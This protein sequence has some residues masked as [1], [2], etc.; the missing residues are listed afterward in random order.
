MTPAGGLTTDYFIDDTGAAHNS[1][2]E[3][4]TTRPQRYFA[5]RYDRDSGAQRHRSRASRIE[6]HR[7][8]T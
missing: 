8:T 4:Q 6:R 7:S 1:Y 5:G 3:F 2:Y